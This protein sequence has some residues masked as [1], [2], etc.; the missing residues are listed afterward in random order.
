MNNPFHVLN[1]PEDADDQ[2]VRKAYL[3][4]VKQYPPEQAPDQFK[5][6]QDAYHC[7]QTEKA[8]LQYRL[9]N[10]QAPSFEQ[11]LEQAFN[12]PE[13]GALTASDIRECLNCALDDD[14]FNLPE[15]RQ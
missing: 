7:T 5:R 1:V 11:W 2:M 6:I 8:R 4:L 15:K 14:L 12:L 3:R 13:A 10:T 9:F